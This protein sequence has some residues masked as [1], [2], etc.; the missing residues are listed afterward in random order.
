MGDF[1]SGIMSIASGLFGNSD[2]PYEAAMDMFKKYFN[3][4]IG[5][6]KPFFEAGKNAIGPFQDWLNTMKDPSGFINNIMG[7]YSQS[8]WAKFLNNQVMNASNNAASASGLLGSTVH[9]RQNADY[10]NKIA[11]GD[12]QS[13]LDRVLGINHEYG[14]GLDQLIGRGQN[15]ANA[16]SELLASLGR[17]M[18]GAA[19]GAEGG[20]N[21]DFGNIISG[22]GS[23]IF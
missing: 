20:R 9:S 10:A 11:S 2:S 18:G 3:Q 19:A 23:L 17:S 1:G 5:Y 8:P 22:I 16:I 15:S 14:G 13:W 7:G 4:G 21:Q 6:Q 12:M